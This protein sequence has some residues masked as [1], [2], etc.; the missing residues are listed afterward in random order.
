[1]IPRKHES[2]EDK[3]EHPLQPLYLDDEGKPR[4]KANNIVRY[5]LNYARDHGV[6]L[7]ELA[8]MPFSD[9][10]FEQFYQL[11]GY[12]LCGYGEL[13]PGSAYKRAATQ[14]VEGK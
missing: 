9:E 10:D 8:S 11:I 1:M 2:L 13:F 7:N 12:T 14:K 4:F 6:G 3:V 5:L